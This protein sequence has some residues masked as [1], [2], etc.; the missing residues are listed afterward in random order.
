[1]EK[2]QVKYMHAINF[3]RSTINERQ[4]GIQTEEDEK[5]T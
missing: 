4:G 1:M 2:L 5:N 3:G